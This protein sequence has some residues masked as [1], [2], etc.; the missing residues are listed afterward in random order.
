MDMYFPSVFIVIFLVSLLV[1]VI[2]V[3]FGFFV[4]RYRPSL[5]M[6]LATLLFGLRSI[7]FID[8]S[9]LPQVQMLL[10]AFCIGFE[11]MFVYRSIR[12]SLGYPVTVRIDLIIFLVLI[13]IGLLFGFFLSYLISQIIFT[14]YVMFFFGKA[15]VL[16]LK[17][18]QRYSG[19]MLAAILLYLAAFTAVMSPFIVDIG[20]YGTNST[21]TWI[22]TTTLLL[23]LTGN[24]GLFFS[25]VIRTTEKYREQWDFART[26]ISTIGHDL[27]GYLGGIRQ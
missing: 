7:F 27:N 10:P 3:I 16:S 6:G 15:F 17:S 12:G 25:A 24:C 23:F 5:E 8:G 13:V 4:Y 1:A 26:L 11:V 14:L 21:Y 2:Q 18:Q 9:M 22:I 19:V 20:S